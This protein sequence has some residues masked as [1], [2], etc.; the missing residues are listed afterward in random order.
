[1]S[2]DLD[3]LVYTNSCSYF[4][5]C[6]CLRIGCQTGCLLVVGSLSSV[7]SFCSSLGY[8]VRDCFNK[9]NRNTGQLFLIQNTSARNVF[10]QT[11][12]YFHTCKSVG[13]TLWSD[14]SWCMQSV[15]FH[16]H[17]P[18]TGTEGKLMHY[19]LGTFACLHP[20]V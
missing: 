7:M 15:S 4:C 16:I 2:L 8:V 5:I 3:A 14:P 17:A 13:L 6:S 9:L 12:E 18:I 11:L 1:M 19:F 10:F 20:V